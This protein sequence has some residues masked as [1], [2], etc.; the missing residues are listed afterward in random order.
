MFLETR[1]LEEALR[2]SVHEVPAKVLKE[3]DGLV[4]CCPQC[5]ETGLSLE[6]IPHKPG[7][8]LAKSRVS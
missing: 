5:W 8:P 4:L 1:K 2:H 3:V 7:C 6:T